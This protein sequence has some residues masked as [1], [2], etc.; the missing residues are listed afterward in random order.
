[1][2]EKYGLVYKIT[3][4]V[5]QRY[6]IGKKCLHKG[7]AWDKYWGSSKDLLADI[8]QHGIQYFTKDI[9]IYCDSSYELS[10]H[11]I[12]QMVRHNWLNDKCYN[13]NM[14]GR[15]FKSKLKHTDENRN[16]TI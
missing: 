9:L 12:D 4:T 5:N 7:K 13:Q 3:N 10:Y 8:K 6:Y 15:Y 16:G 2:L 14:S 1:M 11:E